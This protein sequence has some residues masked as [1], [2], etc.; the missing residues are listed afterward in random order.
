MPTTSCALCDAQNGLSRR[1]SL[2]VCVRVEE[3]LV[4]I[5]HGQQ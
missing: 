3:R 4:E 5:N 1:I 2:C